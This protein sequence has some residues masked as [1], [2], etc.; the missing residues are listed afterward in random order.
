[1]TA[2]ARLQDR[3]PSRADR[4][5]WQHRLLLAAVLVTAAAQAAPAAVTVQRIDSA[6]HVQA[7]A[8][9]QADARTVWN[10]LVGYEQLADFIPDMASSRTLRRNGDSAVVQQRGRA[11]L[12]PF[13]QDFSLTLR[14]AGDAAALGD[15]ASHGGRL[16]P[17]RIE[18]PAAQRRRRQ[19]APRLQRTDRAPGRHP[20]AG[21]RAGDDLGDPAPVRCAGRRDRTPRREACGTTQARGH[22][23][24]SAA[25]RGLQ[26]RSPLRFLN[27][28]FQ[29]IT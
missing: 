16:Q 19:H 29:E 10:T 14:G 18:L 25:L 9:L 3:E 4:P 13:K 28:L 15:G 11:G 27:P 23:A 8:T 5:H 22:A 21:G 26:A 6:L 2:L 12:G 24:L 17:L 7:S 20:A 1:M